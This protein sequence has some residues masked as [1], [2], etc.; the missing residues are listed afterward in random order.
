ME[1]AFSMSKHLFFVC[2]TD[3][4]EPIINQRFKSENYYYSSLGNSLQFDNES[5]RE[6]KRI[7]LS[8]NIDDI[9]FVLFIENRIILDALGKQE[10]SQIKG[11]N[12]L[13][14]QIKLENEHYGESWYPLDTTFLILSSHLNKKIKELRKELE[15][16]ITDQLR[17][18]GKIYDR[19]EQ[20]FNDIYPELIFSESISLN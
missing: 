19:N 20:L 8:H 7:I 10:Y 2:P 4:L 14:Q 5:M 6:I 12:Q 9:S 3:H 15:G 16:S 13:Y 18:H 1:S 17:I 11:L